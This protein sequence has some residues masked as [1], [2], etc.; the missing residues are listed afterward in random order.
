MKIQVCGSQ[1]DSFLSTPL[2]VKELQTVATAVCEL[3]RITS[4]FIGSLPWPTNGKVTCKMPGSCSLKVDR[5]RKPA[6]GCVISNR[7]DLDTQL[8]NMRVPRLRLR[9]DVKLKCGISIH[10]PS[11]DR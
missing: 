10:Q 7:I 2:Q 6:P 4:Y 11:S 3:D 1:D 9:A 8:L 5:A